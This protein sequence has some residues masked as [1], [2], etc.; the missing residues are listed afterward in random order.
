[1]CV[2]PLL[3]QKKLVTYEVPCGHCYQ[4]QQKRRSEWTARLLIEHKEYPNAYF[5]TLT[6]D[7]ENIKKLDYVEEVDLY[8]PKKSDY[9]NFLK[10]FRKKYECRYYGVH[11][12]G[13][14]TYRNHYHIILFLQ[15]EK[16]KIT[17][18]IINDIWGLGNT[19]ID[20][21]NQARMH[22]MTKYLNKP[23]R[24]YNVTLDKLQ[25]IEDY[26]TYTKELKQH[27]LYHYTFNFMSLKPALGSSLFNNKPLIKYIRDTALRNGYYPSLKLIT[28]TFPLP[29][30]YIKKIFT[31]DERNK[32]YRLG[33]KNKSKQELLQANELNLT[34][35][36]LKENKIIQDKK[37]KEALLKIQELKSMLYEKNNIDL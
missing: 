37:K 23:Y 9:Q 21:A 31:E 6:Y 19:T 11:E 7:E 1:M 14:K 29:R 10:R 36:E 33:L 25:E 24:Q 35:D 20:K 15:D 28:K 26:V 16:A 32:I 30:Y 2:Q 13:T 27:I 34:L 8:L 12:Y 3:I 17:N 5:I 18:K 4:C 22:Y